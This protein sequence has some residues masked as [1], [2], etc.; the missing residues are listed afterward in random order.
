M[1]LSHFTLSL[2]LYWRLYLNVLI[3]GI[4]WATLADDGI[5]KSEKNFLVLGQGVNLQNISCGTF[6][7]S[8]VTRKKRSLVC[9]V[10]VWQK[11]NASPNHAEWHLSKIEDESWRQQYLQIR[12]T[13]LV[14]HGIV[15]LYLHCCLFYRLITEFNDCKEIDQCFQN[16]HPQLYSLKWNRRLVWRFK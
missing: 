5:I 2:F 1:L 8:K 9:W 10:S 7:M 16:K 3:T 13:L 6:V 14:V 15:H 12:H 11:W 4:W